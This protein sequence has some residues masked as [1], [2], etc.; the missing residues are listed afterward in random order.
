[1]NQFSLINALHEESERRTQFDRL[2]IE[3]LF[4]VQ[5]YI[6][7]DGNILNER[8]ESF[9]KD[10]REF[11]S[12]G[13]FP[14]FQRMKMKGTAEDENEDGE[15][16]HLDAILF[17]SKVVG[18]LWYYMQKDVRNTAEESFD[19]IVRGLTTQ[20]GVVDN[21]KAMTDR[22]A[23]LKDFA[24]KTAKDF[25]NP[26]MKQTLRKYLD[27]LESYYLKKV[28]YDQVIASLKGGSLPAKTA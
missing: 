2:L 17:M 5:S 18:G 3:D 25:K 13:N 14:L 19:M 16:D 15:I 26:S 8:L 22:Q 11:I 20:S 10:A 6:G 24:E 4:E 12:H 7:E 21:M 28:P 27:A 1:M 23:K 9:L